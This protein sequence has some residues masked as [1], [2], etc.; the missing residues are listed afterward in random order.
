M[1]Q[2]D[3]VVV[4]ASTQWYIINNPTDALSEKL[5]R[6]FSTDTPDPN[7]MPEGEKKYAKQIVY[8]EFDD[9]TFFAVQ[10]FKDGYRSYANKALSTFVE[11]GGVIE[12]GDDIIIPS[13]QTYSN[14][15]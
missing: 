1:A 8:M 10:A 4:R 14:D 9:G 7:S 11:N 3:L 15:V 2:Q 12:G 6:T 5:N 13:G